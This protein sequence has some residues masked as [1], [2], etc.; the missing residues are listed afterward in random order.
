MS[1]L[2]KAVRLVWC[3]GAESEEK[4][5][6]LPHSTGPGACSSE[7][8]RMTERDQNKNSLV[9]DGKTQAISVLSPVV[10]DP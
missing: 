8:S 4:Q 1:H 9:G 10:V 2:L 5:Q 6:D 7:P 3:Q